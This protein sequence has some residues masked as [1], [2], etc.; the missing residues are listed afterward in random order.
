MI[1]LPTLVNSGVQNI[2]PLSND[3]L[4]TLPTTITAINTTGFTGGAITI[5]SGGQSLTF[6]PNGNLVTSQTITYT[7]TDSTGANDTAN[8]VI[9]V[10]QS[11]SY[12]F[13]TN[14]AAN[15]LNACNFSTFSLELFSVDAELQ[16]GSF[17]F[18]DL[19]LTTTYVGNN[20]FRKVQFSG[21]VYRIKPNGEI[22]AIQTCESDI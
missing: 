19:E 5:A 16:I 15:E 12:L 21:M 22:D 3:S 8:I 17:L 1:I 18:T 10:I 14:D 20:Q 6:T 7:I 13:S 11:F 4:G 2:F 9:E